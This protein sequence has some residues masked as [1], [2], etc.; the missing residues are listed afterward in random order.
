MDIFTE[1]SRKRTEWPFA[2]K[3]E[4]K[5]WLVLPLAVFLVSFQL[6][7]A[8]RERVQ[9]AVSFRK[10]PGFL[11]ILLDFGLGLAARTDGDISQTDRAGRE[12][13]LI[14]LAESEKHIIITKAL[15]SRETK[16]IFSLFK[17][18]W[19][20]VLLCAVYSIVPHISMSQGGLFF[21]TTYHWPLFDKDTDNVI[22]NLNNRTR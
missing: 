11:L 21:P 3:K 17:L 5:Q 22:S 10:A 16:R 1:K 13:C 19:S 15:F 2:N 7:G 6:H 8:D 14:L 4:N 9:R 20:C 18:V 12:R